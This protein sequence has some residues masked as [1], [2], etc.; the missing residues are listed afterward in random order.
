MGDHNYVLSLSHL[1]ANDAIPVRKESFKRQ[2][3]RVSYGTDMLGDYAVAA[4]MYG[5][6]RVIEGECG[7]RDIITTSV[8]L[9]ELL[10]NTFSHLGLVETLESTIMALVQSPTLVVRDPFLINC[11]GDLVVGLNTSLED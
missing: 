1:V 10:T 2:L 5:E 9:A 3:Q 6:V 11:I 4:I 7:G 8:T